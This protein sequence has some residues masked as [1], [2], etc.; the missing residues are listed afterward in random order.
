LTLWVDVLTDRCGFKV[1]KLIYRTT[2]Q[3]PVD[4]FGLTDQTRE[5]SRS[6]ALNRIQMIKRVLTGA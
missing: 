2:L 1:L 3:Q 4:S 6:W 5:T